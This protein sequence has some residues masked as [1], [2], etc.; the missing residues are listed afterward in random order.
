MAKAARWVDDLAG[1]SA[2]L[3]AHLIEVCLRAAARRYD[4]LTGYLAGRR[5]QLPP[6]PK[7]EDEADWPK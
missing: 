2:P 5:L 6:G 1:N 7:A 4:E 3:R